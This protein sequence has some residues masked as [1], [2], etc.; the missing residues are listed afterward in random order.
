MPQKKGKGKK[1]RKKKRRREDEM[2]VRGKSDGG[3]LILDLQH[4]LHLY[5]K[6][7]GEKHSFFNLTEEERKTTIDCLILLKQ[8]GKMPDIQKDPEGFEEVVDS[9]VRAAPTKT[10]PEATPNADHIPG[11]EELRE[12]AKTIL[13]SHPRLAQ[14]LQDDLDR[15]EKVEDVVRGKQPSGGMQKVDHTYRLPEGSVGGLT[16]DFHIADFAKDGTPKFARGERQGSFNT[17]YYNR[18]AKT[19]HQRR[20]FVVEGYLGVLTMLRDGARGQATTIEGEK[21]NPDTIAEARLLWGLL[22][23]ARVFEIPGVLARDLYAEVDKH[24]CRLAGVKW[25]PMSE[26]ANIPQE[27]IDRYTSV[28]LHERKLVSLPEKMPFESLYL[29]IEP[30]IK[31]S[32]FQRDMWNAGRFNTAKIIGFLVTH[33]HVVAFILGQIEETESDGTVHLTRGVSYQWEMFH[34]EWVRSMTST[35]WW[36]TWIIEWINDHQ[37]FIEESTHLGSYRRG[38]KKAAKG[39]ISRPIPPPYYAVTMRDALISEEDWLKKF[40]RQLRAI[41][42]RK[43]EH[44]YD[45]RGH[46]C[47][48]VMR[49]P[50]PLEPKLENKLRKD[51]RR[52]IFTM[53]PP[54]AETAAR[55]AKRGFPAKKVDEWLAVLVY[56]RDDHKRGPEDGPYI[57]SIRRSARTKPKE[58]A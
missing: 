58:A 56:W 29:G 7:H 17:D 15:V 30:P 54:D 38:Y 49:G 57:P 10:P 46:W 45:V 53:H 51:K 43:C 18:E 11:I 2:I 23:D 12:K 19:P 20:Q 48:R 37:T 55:L 42:R 41:A 31:L 25:T 40:Q 4:F 36:V 26:S 14:Q 44:Q 50:L 34:H 21:N 28:L 5:E 22:K 6:Y 52:K 13:E 47:V 32:G 8:T 9:M 1:K 16:G 24:V 33:K 39:K 3:D 27:E 35:P